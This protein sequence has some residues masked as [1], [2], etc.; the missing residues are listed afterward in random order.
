MSL[1]HAPPPCLLFVGVSHTGQ[2]RVS[3]TR[4]RGNGIRAHH[5]HDVRRLP[6]VGRPE[7]KSQGYSVENHAEGK[8]GAGY[9]AEG[10]SRS[11]EGAGKTVT[12]ELGVGR[13]VVE[14]CYFHG[15]GGSRVS[16]FVRLLTWGAL[17]IVPT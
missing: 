8:G 10:C 16:D 3:E 9:H 15:R 1:A 6:V 2:G 7:A 11:F 13:S 17:R 4:A 12:L 5:A 14:P